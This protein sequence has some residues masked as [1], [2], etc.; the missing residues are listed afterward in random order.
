MAEKEAKAANASGGKA[1]ENGVYLVEE[2]R[3]FYQHSY[4]W[5]VRVAVI[6][7]VIIAGL[8]IP[9]VIDMLHHRKPIV[10]AVT[11]S[12]QVQPVVPLS[13]PMV[14]DSGAAAWA[15]QAVEHTLSLSFTQW[16]QQLSEASKYY[17]SSAFKQLIIGLKSS[18]I[19]EK[20]VSQRLNTV[21]QPVSAAYVQQSGTINGIPVWMVR[22][23]MILTYEGSAGNI[24][25][26]RIDATIIVQRA[27]LLKHPSGLEIRNI[28]L[29]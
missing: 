27:D 18:G 17:T 21:L 22:G 6:E 14:T 5:I 25:T 7:A 3:A 9:N 23:K 8:L 24:S 2:S 15:T 28:S 16:K 1:R 29:Q 4:Q 11:P 10:I 26:Q 12:M 19:M 20:I 13:E